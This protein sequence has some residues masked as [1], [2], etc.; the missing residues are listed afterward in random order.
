M[1]DLCKRT[2]EKWED[3]KNGTLP[4]V[5]E[6]QEISE[7]LR[8][9]SVCREFSYGKSLSFLL[10]EASR[11]RPPDPSPDFF[12]HITSKLATRDA[13]AQKNGFAE[14]VLAKGWK[15]VPV[16]TAIIIVLIS[17]IAYQYTSLLPQ[18]VESS[19]EERILF[20]D[21]VLEENDILAAIVGGEISNGKQ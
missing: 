10:Q 21:A 12:T 18:S 1:K 14:I 2:K 9:C 7:H 19:L 20:G 6:E 4:T 5:Q 15:L 8:N 3:Y 16:M 11:E 17:S 13:Q